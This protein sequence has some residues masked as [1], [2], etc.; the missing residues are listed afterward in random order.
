M[1]SVEDLDVFKTSSSVG[2]EDVLVNQEISKG[3][4]L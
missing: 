4:R 1:K 3:K 2:T